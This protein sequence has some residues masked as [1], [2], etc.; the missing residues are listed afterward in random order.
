MMKSKVKAGLALGAIALFMGCQERVVAPADVA[1]IELEPEVLTLRIGSS[2]RFQARVFDDAG[3]A[4]TGRDVTWDIGDDAIGAIADDGTVIA[5]AIGQTTVLARAGG[6]Q[7]VATLRVTSNTIASVEVVPSEASLEFGSTRS[8]DVTV[9][10]TDGTEITGRAATWT[11]SAPAIAA[12]D[13]AGVVTGVGLGT[14]IITAAID[15]IEGTAS[16]DIVAPPLASMTVEPSTVSLQVGQQRR[17]T[18]IGQRPDGTPVPGLPVAWRSANTAV[19]TVDDTGLVTGV[20]EGTVQI[21]AGFGGVLGAATVAVSP[22]PAGSIEV[23]PEQPSILVNDTLRLT[24]VVRDADGN[25]IDRTPDWSS[26]AASIATVS[27]SGLV[28]GRASGFAYVIATLDG[29][30]DSALVRVAERPVAAVVVTPGET[31]L[32]AD[33]TVQLTAQVI[34]DDGSQ[35][36]R[37]ISWS[38]SDTQVATVNGSGLVTA[39]SSGV[40]II[41]ATAGGVTGTA[42]VT[43]DPPPITRLEM[44]PSSLD[45]QLGQTGQLTVVGFTAD[46]TEVPNPGATW[47][48]TNTAVA[49]VSGGTVTAVAGGT[50]TIIASAQGLEVAASVTVSANVPASIDID[51]GNFSF[52]VGETR[53]LTATVRNAIGQEIDVPVSWSTR[54]GAIAAVNPTGVVTGT[55]VGSTYIVASV[56][57][58]RDSVQV[59]VAQSPITSIR[60]QPATLNIEDGASAQ[61]TVVGIRQNGTEVPGL[62]ASGWTSSNTNVATVN[63]SGVVTGR[64][65]GSAQVSAEWEDFEASATVNVTSDDPASISI[66]GGDF[67]LQVGASRQLTAT[68]R[69]DAGSPVDASVSWSSKS[70]SI[71]S[72]SGSGRVDAKAPGGTYIVAATGVLRDSVEVTV[73]PSPAAL[74]TVEP[75]AATIEED[76]SVTLRATVYDASGNVIDRTVAWSTNQTNIVSVNQNG[77]VT[78]KR[79]GVAFVTASVDGRSATAAITVEDDEDDDDDGDAELT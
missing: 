55:G 40:A 27:T 61:L 76:E 79:E 3:N 49:T 23:T 21:E 45:L 41:R 26:T 14:S 54:N 78:G 31:T 69:N 74:V 60:V 5:Q 57:T 17:L 67:S 30:R 11:S 58:L 1:R 16:V 29:V 25:V 63:G 38:S 66:D 39:R 8:F 28:R 68:V 42:V 6:R 33:E 13:D 10:A 4:L 46:G 51:Q 44:R 22:I 75:L 48:S 32:Q 64:G 59:T 20:G 35:Q 53:T 62:P 19:A 71:A 2:S 72:V 12:V 9:T 52:T 43:V 36:S 34:A 7:G 77:R 18:A 65:T 15:G 70:G 47:R 50:A 37:D 73:T 24:A 56:N